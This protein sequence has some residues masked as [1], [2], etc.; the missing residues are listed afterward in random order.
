MKP[1]RWSALPVLTLLVLAA[2]VAQRAIPTDV[3]QVEDPEP[4]PDRPTAPVVPGTLPDPDRPAAEQP[5]V[6]PDS[7]IIIQ[8]VAPVV[9][10]EQPR[11]AVKGP[12]GTLK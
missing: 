2:P 7:R 10:P 6:T 11:P 1:S 12:A 5:P 3:I 9:Q 8:P 4:L